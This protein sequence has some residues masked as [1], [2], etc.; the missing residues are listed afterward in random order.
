MSSRPPALPPSDSDSDGSDSNSAS[1]VD[2]A[3]ASDASDDSAL[4]EDEGAPIDLEVVSV[5]TEKVMVARG[6]GSTG[7]VLR[8]TV[9][10]RPVG[11]GGGVGGSRE[12]PSAT[13]THEC[14]MKVPRARKRRVV[15]FGLASAVVK[16]EVRA[17]DCLRPLQPQGMGG[18]GGVR[19]DGVPRCYGL[20]LYGTQ[21]GLCMERVRGRHFDRFHKIKAARTGGDGEDGRDGGDG[22]E[23]KG[24]EGKNGVSEGS[25]GKGGGEGG[26]GDGDGKTGNP[27]ETS[28]G[29]SATKA[30]LSPVFV[31]QMGCRLISILERVHCC[32]VV[33]GDLTPCNVIYDPD[34]DRLVLLDFGHSSIDYA[35]ARPVRPS[36]C[37]SL[38]LSAPLCPSSAMGYNVFHFRGS[39]AEEAGGGRRRPVGCLWR[40][41]GGGG[42]H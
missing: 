28:S 7:K 15:G 3:S 10:T 42:G 11:G 29:K 31:A 21:Y 34:T 9:E 33:H 13:T 17:F 35:R 22:G 24:G 27:S 37:P 40:V 26:G 30:D 19:E 1:S 12:T 5:D 14:V 23:G 8:C 2:D 4:G 16:R 6:K 36:L 38:S 32:G 18:G 20:H 39:T 41:V 25:E